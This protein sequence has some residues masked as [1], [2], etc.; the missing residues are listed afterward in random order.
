M[1][2]SFP[3][4]GINL[5][6]PMLSAR[7]REL[8][9]FLAAPGVG[10]LTEEQRALALN[11][12]RRLIGDVAAR[13][14]PGTD[15]TSLWQEW[16]LTGVPGADRLAGPC[17]ARAEEHR[18]RE[19]S[20]QHMTPPPPLSPGG[21]DMPADAADPVAGPLSD[22]DGAYLALQIADRRRFDALGAPCLAL[23]DLDGVLFRSTLQDV[24]GW[25][26]RQPGMTV[27]LATSLGD[28]VDALI[29]WHGARTGIDAAAAAYHAAL[30]A[31]ATLS[32][33][34]ATAIARHDWPALIALIA[35]THRRNYGDMALKLLT[36]Q[37]AALPSLLAPLRLDRPALAPLEASLAMLPDRAVTGA[38]GGAEDYA[39]LLQSRLDGSAGDGA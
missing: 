14:D 35:V 24:A 36:A 34:A 16:A 4:S 31:S 21:A 12:A 20:A 23:C 33:A 10:R 5:P 37:T 32:D 30:E 28:A 17:F 15:W 39:A 22:I 38:D 18:W 25:W 6:S 8:A 27:A 7:L 26:L 3:S 19:Q 1:A 9:D 2:E 29:E 11:I 13:L